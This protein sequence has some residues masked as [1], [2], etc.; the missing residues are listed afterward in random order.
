MILEGENYIGKGL[1]LKID[2]DGEGFDQSTGEYT[3]E[4]ICGNKSH[5]YT[6]EDIYEDDGEY[7]LG[8]DTSYFKA[9]TLKLIITA[10]IPDEAFP[11]GIRKEIDVKTIG[12]LKTP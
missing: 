3:V 5:T 11:N 12:I 9:G 6:K 10:L 7:Y 4:A 8:I 2:I 1:K